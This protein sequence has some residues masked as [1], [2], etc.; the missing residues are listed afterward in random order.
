MKSEEWIDKRAWGEGPW[1]GEPD[2]V[3]WR[4]GNK[5]C[6]VKR[7][8]A[9]G[10]F[11]GYVGLQRGHKLYGKGYDEAHDFMEID[12]HGGLTYAGPC[13]EAA[14]REPRELICHVPEPGESHNR[15]WL[16]FDC[17]HF[18]DLSPKLIKDLKEWGSFIEGA[19]AKDVYRDID[20][21]MDEVKRLADQL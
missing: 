18:M 2:R 16:G 10:H 8:P 20:Y 13:E 17:A 1:Q 11:C 4:E 7:H 6:L 19:H 14:G 5:V 9:H 15:W 12:V 3:E 21:V